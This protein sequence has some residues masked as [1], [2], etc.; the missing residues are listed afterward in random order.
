[1]AGIPYGGGDPGP[2]DVAMHR[3]AT[4][5]KPVGLLRC[6]EGATANTAD[7]YYVAS[8]VTSPPATHP[9]DPHSVPYVAI[10]VGVFDEWTS[11]A[12]T[13]AY[14]IQ[15]KSLDD[16]TRKML[17]A[18]LRWEQEILVT[19]STRAVGY[20]AVTMGLYVPYAVRIKGARIQLGGATATGS[21]TIKVWDDSTDM[22][23]LAGSI[24]QG[25]LSQDI[26]GVDVAVAAGSRIRVEM[27]GV[28]TGGIGAGLSVALFGEYDLAGV[29]L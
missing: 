21:T 23:A 25:N 10:L 9:N 7:P 5:L 27:T 6:Q 4:D 17:K 13:P 18:G 1:M 29:T 28:G 22:T 8:F 16:N 26:T 3:Q 14:F 19:T 12:S 11:E 24:P 15:G 20:G 2:G